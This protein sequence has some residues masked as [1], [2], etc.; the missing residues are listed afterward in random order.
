MGG[1]AP[2]RD[3]RQVVG[4]A[5][6]LVALLLAP[7]AAATEREVA[8]LDYRSDPSL[9]ECGDEAEFRNRVVL[10]LGYDPFVPVAPLRVTVRLSADRGRVSSA[11]VFSRDRFELG[12]R[13]L[14]EDRQRCSVLVDSVAAAV[15]IAIDPLHSPENRVA[16]A[17]VV[18]PSVQP[19]ASA[20]A[21]PAP[22]PAPASPPLSSNAPSL[23]PHDTPPAQAKSTPWFPLVSAEAVV[24]LGV[25]PGAT[26][27]AQ[28][29][30]GLRH[31][32]GSYSI[33]GRAEA[34]PS[35][36]SLTPLDRVSSTV[37]SGAF[38]PCVHASVIAVCGVL[39]AGSIQSTALDVSRP[40]IAAAFI[41]AAALRVGVAIPVG[42]SF[43]FRAGAEGGL[44][45]SRTSYVING[46]IVWTPPPVVGG[47]QLGAMWTFR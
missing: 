10:R 7:E 32:I 26:V 3:S 38:V 8:T 45:L 18:A 19:V 20:P 5:T 23:A 13:V 41:G 42:T 9:T 34:T 47:V 16:P 11:T 30:F 40:K 43:A 39:R 22:A 6:V 2:R 12:K 1:T 36:V 24:G 37:F 44:P 27:G 33:E 21:A 14:V 31:G 15:A 46:A 25:A 4:A 35:A 17:P 29:G 28:V